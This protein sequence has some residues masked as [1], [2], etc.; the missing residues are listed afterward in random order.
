MF[1]SE[2]LVIVEWV[3]ASSCL[4]SKDQFSKPITW[5]NSAAMRL[6]WDGP[7]QVISFLQVMLHRVGFY[8]SKG[9]FCSGVG[10]HY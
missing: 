3:C 7:G 10:T 5:L 8:G 4:D 6:E 1:S 9:D 2:K